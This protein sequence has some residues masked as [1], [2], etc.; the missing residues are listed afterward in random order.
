MVPIFWECQLLSQAHLLGSKATFERRGT[1]FPSKYA[2]DRSD[3]RMLTDLSLQSSDFLPK[4][5]GQLLRCSRVCSPPETSVMESLGL[6]VNVYLRGEQTFNFRDP[7][8]LAI[9]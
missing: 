7:G 2:Q 5:M 6:Q 3:R 1:N 9:V 8:P 4:S